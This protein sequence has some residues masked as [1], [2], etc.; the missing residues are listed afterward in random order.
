MHNVSLPT[1][2][3]L[4]RHLLDSLPSVELSFNVPDILA[5]WVAGLVQV[6]HE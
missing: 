5:Q 3:G 2:Q 4:A 1:F 6:R